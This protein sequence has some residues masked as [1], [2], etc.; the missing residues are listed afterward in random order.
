VYM[1]ATHERMSGE[2]GRG[3]ETLWC[4]NYRGLWASLG[5]WELNLFLLEEQRA[6]LT[7]EPSPQSLQ[8]SLSHLMWLESNYQLFV[9][10]PIVVFNL[11]SSGIH[12]CGSPF[13][14][15]SCALRWDTVPKE[16]LLFLRP[17]GSRVI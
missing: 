7:V 11:F 17:Q 10:D 3:F 12:L 9:V 4:W 13:S 8:N 1:Y 5:C 2:A 16:N 15:V 6:P 14:R